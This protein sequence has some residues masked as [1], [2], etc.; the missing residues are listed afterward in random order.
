MQL[1]LIVF[2]IDHI[3]ITEKLIDLSR[4]PDRPVK[5]HR[6]KARSTQVSRI[7]IAFKLGSVLE[8]YTRL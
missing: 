3:C 4:F 8:G 2:S 7:P 5:S 1:L 6:D